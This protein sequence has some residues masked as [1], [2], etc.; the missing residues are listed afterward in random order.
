MIQIV[1]ATT[2]HIKAIQ[3]VSA[4]AWPNAFK[5]ILSTAQIAYMMEWMYSDAS[6]R[7][8]MEEKKHRYFLS[9]AE[10]ENMGY[11]SRLAAIFGIEVE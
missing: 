3:E 4:I 10:D 9:I 1:P 2:E 7:E 6:L 8:Q 11:M 5:D